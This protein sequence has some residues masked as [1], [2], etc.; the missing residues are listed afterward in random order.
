MS[1]VLG[2][3]HPA[4]TARVSVAPNATVASVKKTIA[5][6]LS[7]PATMRL[8][9]RSNKELSPDSAAINS[10]GITN[11]D[12][13]VV[14]IPLPASAKPV[15]TLPPVPVTTPSRTVDP[16]PT[17]TPTA[18]AAPVAKTCPCKGTQRCLRCMTQPK[19]ETGYSPA[20]SAD[21]PPEYFDPADPRS[22]QCRH[23]PR[24]R[25]L[26]C[27]VA[28][29]ADGKKP[30]TGFLSW[31]CT[32]RP[33]QKCSNCLTVSAAEMAAEKTRLAQITSETRSLPC[34][35]GPGMK[36]INCSTAVDTV[37]PYDPD[38]DPRKHCRHHGPQGS[39]LECMAALDAMV[40]VVKSQTAGTL[41]KV[42]VG[43]GV[44]RAFGQ[45]ML[46]LG[47]S[48]QRIGILYGR[49]A[50]DGQSVYVD[51]VYEPP[52]DS[53]DSKVTLKKDI[54]AERIDA[55][56]SGFGWQRVGWVCAH[57]M[58]EIHV[59]TPEVMLAADFQNQFGPSAVTLMCTPTS[60]G[61]FTFEAYQVSEQATGLQGKQWFAPDQPLHDAV[62]LAPGR[63]VRLLDRLVDRIPTLYLICNVAIIDHESPLK[64]SFA[65]ENRPHTPQ[66]LSDYTAHMKRNAHK[67]FLERVDDFHLLVFLS[68]FLSPE[69]MKGL[70]DAVSKRN[71]SKAEGFKYVIDDLL[72]L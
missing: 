21:A 52:Q 7:I 45:A 60:A 29:S 57:G 15:A 35:H 26:S 61:G 56:A 5:T 27:R 69:D 51:A 41:K 32:H 4:G 42:S 34:T 9:T 18:A 54:D 14:D 22:P 12:L 1:I 10:L 30:G 64:H 43:R 28:P 23:G 66:T 20:A 17:G 65:V 59:T 71:A 31:K 68:N 13:I 24:E 72:G 3:R 70:A 55:L 16:V 2:V 49:F 47:F 40:P 6:Q 33:D 39:C 62:M 44:S 58:R 25:C 53:T 63:Q 67:S 11:Q 48:L 37:D 36:C 46:D 50:D 8:L 38:Y 19:V